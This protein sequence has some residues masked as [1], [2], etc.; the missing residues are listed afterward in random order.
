MK[1]KK[2]KVCHTQY[3]PTRP[4]QKVCSPT[5]ALDMARMI[6]AKKV[7]KEKQRE[8]RETK[9]KLEAMATKPQLLKKAQSAFNTYIRLRDF[10]KQCIC[11]DRVLEGGAIGGGYDAGHFRSVGS[12][13]HLR[14]DE[15]NCH[16]QTKYCNNFL[17]GNHVAYRAGLIKRIGLE[18]VERLEA[19][20]EPKHYTKDDLVELAKHYRSKARELIQPK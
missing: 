14:F 19:D 2:C 16:G 17:A 7:A 13:P 15:Q 10:G 6:S 1:Q 5:C 8:K 18:A 4:L 20:N 9:A 3:T 12:A 11:C